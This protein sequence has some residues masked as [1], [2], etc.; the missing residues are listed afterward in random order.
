L[1]IV[2][3]VREVEPLFLQQTRIAVD[4]EYLINSGEVITCGQG[5]SLSKISIIENARHIARDEG[6]TDNLYSCRLL[7]KIE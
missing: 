5:K 4:I 6:L 3:S 2:F 7:E 1:K